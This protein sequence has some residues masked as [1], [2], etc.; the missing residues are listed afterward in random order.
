MCG[1]VGVFCHGSDAAPV[2]SES[3]ERALV[4]MAPRGPDGSGIWV[5]PRRDVALGHR[6]LAIIDL[7]DSAAQPMT[8][9][10]E[11]LKITFNGEIYNY[12]ELQAHLR[13]L[14]RTLQTD[15]DTEV[16]LHLYSVY[17]ES[18]CEFLRG[19]FAFGIW[20]ERK[21]ALFLARDHFGIKP[22]YVARDGKQLFF[23]SQVKAI[24]A[25]APMPFSPD[26]AGHAGF[27]LWGN[28][29]QTYTLYR[30]IRELTP[31]STMWVD[32]HGVREAR[33]YFSMSDEL[34]KFEGTASKLTESEVNEHVRSA[35][36]DTVRHHF[37]SDVPVGVFLSAGRDSTTLL[38]VS[39]EVLNTPPK[40]ITLGFKE[41]E[42]TGDDEVPLAAEV[43]H[44]YGSEHLQKH[45]L[46]AEFK[47]DLQN[48]LTSM[49]QPS[50]DGLNTYFV[51]KV[52]HEFGIKV[53]LSGLGGDEVFGGYGSF[54]QIPKLVSGIR[55]LQTFPWVGRFFRVVSSGFMSK[56][57]SPK[58]AG[59]LEYGGSYGGAYLLR[60]GLF[61]PWELPGL[62]GAEMAADGWSELKSISKMNQLVQGLK[63]DRSRV[64]ALETLV[65]MK[66]RLLR[67]S[68]WAGMAHS[69][70][71]RVPF[72]DIGFFRA[73]TPL[74]GTTYQPGKATMAMAPSKSLPDS[75]LNRPKTGFNIP[76]REWLVG[77]RPETGA[78][79]S[80]RGWSRVV[81]R[82]L[83]KT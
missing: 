42:G 78:E 12:K 75:I 29:P 20:D 39:T 74:F 52:T 22:L 14:G 58:Y 25:A 57:T 83:N 82:E 80:L 2:E 34:A 26:P 13:S 62:I 35:I 40:A 56:M 72:V 51:S 4:Q 43:A 24:L 48:I 36:L 45:V 76:V 19:M 61:M 67:D 79:R 1:I 81:Y 73:I 3:L 49:D 50:V 15:S 8:L 77:E 6:R 30:Q 18:M 54:H 63:C 28:M 64:S 10:P 32:E 7:S 21:R 5:G 37:V 59:L 68:D 17:G 16:L 27:F 31:G 23:A 46:G 9:E 55:P 11:G 66:N 53:A 38:G 65:Y 41:Y 33:P 70:E 60:R 44:Y 69:L 71:I 47:Q